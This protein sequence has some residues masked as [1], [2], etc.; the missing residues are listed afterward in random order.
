MEDRDIN[1]T[2]NILYKGTPVV[3]LRG[4]R[5]RPDAP[6]DEAMKQSKD[7]KQIVMSQI[8]QP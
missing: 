2:R 7:A 4:L 1:A 5:L 8:N 6:Q 3:Q